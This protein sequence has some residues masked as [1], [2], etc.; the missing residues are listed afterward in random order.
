MPAVMGNM[1]ERCH[2]NTISVVAGRGRSDVEVGDQHVLTE[3][4]V[5]CPAWTVLQSDVVDRQ[6]IHPQQAQER[7]SLAVAG[8]LLV[9]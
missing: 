2:A 4:G 7:W 8:A 6:A 1:N 5:S 9:G 3:S